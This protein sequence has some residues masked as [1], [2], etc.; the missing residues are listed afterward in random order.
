[1][2]SDEEE[3][4]LTA[5]TSIA[6]H[7]Q[8]PV[9]PSTAAPLLSSGWANNGQRACQTV[10]SRVL[11]KSSTA[12]GS[13]STALAAIQSQN[14][15]DSDEAKGR[16]PNFWLWPK[17]EKQRWLA[18]KSTAPLAPSAWYMG[19]RIS[20]APGV[21]DRGTRLHVPGGPA[22]ALT[23]AQLSK[24]D[25]L[26]APWHRHLQRLLWSL[27]GSADK[28]TLLPHQ[29][30]SALLC[31]GIEAPWPA[32]DLTTSAVRSLISSPYDATDDAQVARR[33]ELEPIFEI[34]R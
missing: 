31:A 18:T 22:P 28:F 8:A 2:S 20:R 11:T 16:P 23:D 14:D 4:F 13:S 32:E 27:G 5:F 1:M 12:L 29:F 6:R 30:E 26:S 19:G 3:A 7:P 10:P 9:G 34:H 15:S 21:A 17:E 33:R 24:L 25:S